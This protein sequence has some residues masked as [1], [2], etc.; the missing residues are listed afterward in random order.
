MDFFCQFNQFFSP[1]CSYIVCETQ[2]NQR[3]GN[4][5]QARN[6]HQASFV[7]QAKNN[8][9]ILVTY[10]FSRL[11]FSDGRLFSPLKPRENLYFCR[12]LKKPPVCVRYA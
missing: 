9:Y 7:V 1:G 6:E 8:I 12:L 3:N 2:Y 10:V 5:T 11:N 4:K